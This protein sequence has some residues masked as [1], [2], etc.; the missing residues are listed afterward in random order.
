MNE[1]QELLYQNLKS[2]KDVWRESAVD[3]LNPNTDLIAW[4]DVEESLKI[5][6]Q[7]LSSREEL[8]A[9]RKVVNNVIEGVMHSI[10]VM[11]DGGNE[12]ADKFLVDLID[13][14]TKESLQ[15]DI[16]LHEEFYGYLLDKEE[17]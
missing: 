15:E 5:M 13:R 12:L 17:V 16:A 2:I 8:E 10:L 7:K 1:K 14:D 4:T 9:Y 6:Q 3:S 11:I